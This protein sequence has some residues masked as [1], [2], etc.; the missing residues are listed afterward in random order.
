MQINNCYII[1]FM[2]RYKRIALLFTIFISS[3]IVVINSCI[4]FVCIVISIHLTLQTLN[5]NNQGAS[6]LIVLNNRINQGWS[7]KEVIF[8]KSMKFI[9]LNSVY[10]ELCFSRRLKYKILITLICYKLDTN[11]I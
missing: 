3:N 7:L 10:A 5:I 2:F 4:R 11:T 6:N 9:K 1:I 8:L